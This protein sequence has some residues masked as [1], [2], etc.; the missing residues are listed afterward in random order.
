M[1]VLTFE[2]TTLIEK[3]ISTWSPR[4]VKKLMRNTQRVFL[5]KSFRIL[6][7][8]LVEL[9]FDRKLQLKQ[10]ELHSQFLQEYSACTKNL[11]TLLPRIS[12]TKI[13][14]IQNDASVLAT[15]VVNY[16]FQITKSAPQPSP[17]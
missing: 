5:T 8:A 9:S 3:L 13:L 6:V 11:L 2:W 15:I 14:A 7:K 1:C 17:S 12:S 4:I 10:Y 16:H